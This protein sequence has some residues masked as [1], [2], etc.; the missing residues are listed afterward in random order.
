VIVSDDTI[1]YA[2]KVYIEFVVNTSVSYI[3]LTGNMWKTPIAMIGCPRARTRSMAQNCAWGEIF[4]YI[5]RN[6]CATTF[7][8]NLCV[9][10][11]MSYINAAREATCKL[12]IVWILC[13]F[14][15]QDLQKLQQK[16]ATAQEIFRMVAQVKGGQ[17]N[18]QPNNIWHLWICHWWMLSCWGFR[19]LWRERASNG[20][21]VCEATQ[22]E[23]PT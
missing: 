15:P 20:R 21:Q 9:L 6:L 3:V 8:Y 5:W 14:I 7:A 4:R 1:P 23:N 16:L 11:T 18:H 12:S 10:T 22:L 17:V 13:L 2:L 19:L